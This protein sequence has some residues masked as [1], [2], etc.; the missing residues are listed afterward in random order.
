[1]IDMKKILCGLFFLLFLFP[2]TNLAADDLGIDEAQVEKHERDLQE[3]QEELKHKKAG[4]AAVHKREE[5][6]LD[7]LSR[8]EKKLIAREEELRRLDSKYG[9][10]RKNITSVQG[11][12]DRIQ[13]EMGHNQARLN[14]RTVALYKIWR[15]GYFPYLLSSET[16]NDF[17]R[18][19]RFLKIV[20]DHDANLLSQYQAQW[21]EKRQH[22]DTLAKEI[23]HLK[24]IRKDRKGKKLEIVRAKR[25]KESFLHTVRRE[26][27]NYRRWIRELENQAQ[28]LQLLVKKLER[29]ERG[30]GY[31]DLNF[32]NQKGRLSLPVGGS[33]L[34][35]NRGRGIVINASR[36]TPIKAVYSG[37]I[38]YSG[39][40]EGYGNIII[41]DHG[42]KYYTVSAHASKLLKKINDR[43]R[44][45]D[46]IAFVGD[47]GSLGG[48][49]LYFEI[50]YQGK[51]QD[52]LEWLFI[53]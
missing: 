46:V 51:L 36:D 7:A 20:I 4:E 2:G 50:R 48:P 17:L 3:I 35:D 24:R 1:M 53:P 41:I 8:I 10:I 40:F 26:K 31:S 28:E 19:V 38:I 6:I 23:E 22:Q 49:C 34:P 12:L 33:I 5:S 9:R 14:S 45:G 44:K 37:R 32:K 18:M 13:N 15:V 52:P 11:K 29:K 47:T 16:Y 27:A 43:V 21:L 42:E 30:R 25:E 39:W